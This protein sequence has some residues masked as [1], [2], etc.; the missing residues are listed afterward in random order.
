M[1]DGS[2]D[3]S[4]KEQLVICFRWVDD[5]FEIHED[6]V[7]L[8]PLPNTKNDSTVKVILDVIHRMGPKIENARDQCYDGAATMSDTKCGIATQIKSSNKNVLYTHC[9]GYALNL[10]VN[11]CIR[12]IEVLKYT[13]VMTKEVCNLCNRIYEYDMPHAFRPCPLEINNN[14]RF[15]REYVESCS[16]TT[17]NIITPL[18]QYPWSPN[19]PG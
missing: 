9:Y 17:K 4:N 15:K 8:H 14:D 2:A 18:P 7:G 3:I 6:F 1:P 5:D 12:K 13:W 16:S 11:D 10:G 19:L